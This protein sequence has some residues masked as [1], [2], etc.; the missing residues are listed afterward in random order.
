V[1]AALSDEL[2]IGTDLMHLWK[3]RL[4]LAREDILVDKKLIPRKLA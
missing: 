2:I 4:E 1:A 3:I